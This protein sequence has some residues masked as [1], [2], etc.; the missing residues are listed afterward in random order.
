MIYYPDETGL[1]SWADASLRLLRYNSSPRRL[2]AAIRAVFELATR[3]IRIP[4]TEV[5]P[6]A[7][8]DVLDSRDTRDYVQRVEPSPKGGEKMAAAF[9]D[10]LVTQQPAGSRTSFGEEDPL[11]AVELCPAPS[12][13]SFESFA[14]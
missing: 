7:L 9:I 13:G 11:A 14:T 4:G 12:P 8:F 5:V 10:L 3:R 2:Q 6:V 1:G